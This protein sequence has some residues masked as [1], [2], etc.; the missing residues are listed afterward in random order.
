MNLRREWQGEGEG[1]G[2]GRGRAGGVEVTM[3][4]G[5]QFC[6]GRGWHLGQ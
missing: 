5:I 4:F 6:K 3:T 1:G 2:D